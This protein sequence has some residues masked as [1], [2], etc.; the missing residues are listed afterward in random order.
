MILYK[1]FILLSLIYR[2]EWSY[3]NYLFYWVLYIDTNDP[4]Q[5]IYFIEFYIY[6]YEWSY[7]NYLFY[8]V[9]YIDTNDPIQIIYVIESYI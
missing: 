8:W 2:Y 7:T 1:W 9:L 3:T 4:I 6:R 5:M